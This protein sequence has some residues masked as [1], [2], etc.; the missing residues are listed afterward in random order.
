[1]D[2]RE[3]ERFLTRIYSP[4]DSFEVLYKSEGDDGKVARKTHTFHGEPE[5]TADLLDEFE[6]AE[7]GGFNVYV[8]AMPRNI[9]E[10]GDFD[11][12]W[13][14]QDDVAAPWPFG[15]DPAFDGPQWPAPTTL[16]KTSTEDNGFRWQ[17]IWLLDEDTESTRARVI[18][19]TLAKR[20]GADDSV[21]D[22]RRVLRVP[23]IMNAKRG[24][25]AR[26][27][28]TSEGDTNLSQFD[29]PK[30]SPV[31][32]LLNQQIQNPA[33]VLG[34]WLDGAT[35]GDRN[36][37]A[38]VTARFLKGCGVQYDDAAA[39]LM[40]GAMR[41]EPELEEHEVQHALDSAYHRST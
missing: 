20:I 29:L 1:M 25:A 2:R 16:V 37:K 36:R 14:D 15:A 23:G 13:V 6:R 3:A 22:A 32:A 35:E 18:M 12:V 26:L 38:Y 10:T 11:R 41:C 5:A 27:M 24:T 19:K 17:A 28:D 21:H 4:G 34:E 31:Q 40:L 33:H 7:A 30:D 9:Q 8:S 39:I